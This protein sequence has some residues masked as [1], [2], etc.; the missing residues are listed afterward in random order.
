MCI[1]NSIKI[2]ILHHLCNAIFPR[3]TR[4]KHHRCIVSQRRLVTSLINEYNKDREVGYTLNIQPNR[5]IY[6]FLSVLLTEEGAIYEIF[7]GQ[8][9]K[10]DYR[11]Y[12]RIL[13][14]GPFAQVIDSNDKTSEEEGPQTPKDLP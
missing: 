5:V 14:E 2:N 7:I 9:N 12:I 4:S 3:L 6:E 13:P 11:Y 1:S 8:C 10:H